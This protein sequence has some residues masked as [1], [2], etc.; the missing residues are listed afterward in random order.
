MNH[1][2]KSISFFSVFLTVFVSFQSCELPERKPKDH[3]Y[4]EFINSQDLEKKVLETY[5]NGVDKAVIYTVKNDPTQEN[6]KEIHFYEDAKTQVEGTMKNGLRHGHWTFYHKNG[7]IWSTGSFE[8]GKSVGRFDIFDIDGK[9]KVKSYYE[10]GV[11]VKEEY[12]KNGVLE[13]SVDLT[14]KR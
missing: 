14:K 1:L 4:S 10:N 12:F 11:K 6:V 2:L 9:I 3:P 13:R 8:E 5:E 7:K